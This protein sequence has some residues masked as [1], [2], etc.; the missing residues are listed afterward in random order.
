MRWDVAG[1]VRLSGVGT[2]LKWDGT[3]LGGQ[4]K[5]REE[6]KHWCELELDDMSDEL[7]LNPDEL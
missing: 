7:K 3:G 6:Q 1:T 2:E 4:S 5:R